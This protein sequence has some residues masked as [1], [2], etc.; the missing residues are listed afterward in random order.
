MLRFPIP[1]LG[2]ETL[3]EAILE[4]TAST[5]DELV[6]LTRAFL[7]AGSPSV[8]VSLWEV[9]ARSTKQ[10]MLE[11]YTLLKNGWDKATALQEAQKRIMKE[12]SHPYY[13]APFVLVGDWE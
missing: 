11:F 1:Q 12:N 7:Y 10:L 5:V 13:W 9:D 8:V 4:P 3:L 2:D 6:G